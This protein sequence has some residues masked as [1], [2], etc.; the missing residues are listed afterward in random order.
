MFIHNPRKKIWGFNILPLLPI[1]AFALVE[2]FIDGL[3]KHD[4][5]PLILK[6]VQ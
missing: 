6:Y 1:I 2:P 4:E 5:E 3:Y